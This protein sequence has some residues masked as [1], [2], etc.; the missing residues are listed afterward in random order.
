MSECVGSRGFSEGGRF[1]TWAKNTWISKARKREDIM[2]N[3][4]PEA[5]AWKWQV[6]PA[7][8]SASH[9][10]CGCI[11]NRGHGAAH[12]PQFPE[13]ESWQLV[14]SPKISPQSYAPSWPCIHRASTTISG[15]MRRCYLNTTHMWHLI[16]HNKHIHSCISVIFNFKITAKHQTWTKYV[17]KASI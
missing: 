1:V 4:T 11:H 15:N 5:S 16:P 17:T 13:Q 6:A 9:S 7:H 12:A 3:L 8:T 10:R 2:G 14:S